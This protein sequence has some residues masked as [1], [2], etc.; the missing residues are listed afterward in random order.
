MSQPPTREHSTQH[1]GIAAADPARW[2]YPSATRSQLQISTAPLDAVQQTPTFSVIVPVYEH[3]HLVPELLKR[4]DSQTLPQ[5][6]F[7]V[8][9]VDNG[10]ARFEPPANLAANT[11]V[12]HCA[13]PG[14]YAA[15]NHA[16]EHA[17]GEWTVFTDADCL[18]REDW[19]QSLKRHAETCGPKAVVLAG[20]V[21]MVPANG[22][23]NAYEMYDLVKGIPQGWYVSRGYATTANLAA[24]KALLTQ[25]NGFETNRYSGADAAF[26]RKAVASGASLQYVHDAVVEHPARNTWAALATKARRVKGG[27]LTGGTRKQRGLW[28]ARTFTPPVI[29]FWRFLKTPGPPIRY[30]LVAIAVQFRIWALEMGEATRLLARG[31]AE[32]R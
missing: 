26:C 6:A 3:W 4:L 23:P 7:E 16:L 18:P 12:L 2:T 19:L 27:Q 22:K 11:R 31:V 10:S 30:R 20:A 17:N 29:A 21:Q 13:R 15:R 8:L 5:T 24:R 32:R 9:L 28:L 1:E 14:S 25:L